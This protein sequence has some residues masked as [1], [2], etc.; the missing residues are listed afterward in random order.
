MVVKLA[1][2]E[3][4][5]AL[6][7]PRNEIPSA[8]LALNRGAFPAVLVLVASVRLLEQSILDCAF[9]RA[10]RS[11]AHAPSFEEN[12]LEGVLVRQLDVAEK[13]TS[14]EARIDTV[15]SRLIDAA[16]RHDQ[17]LHGLDSESSSRAVILGTSGGGG[18]NES[19]LDVGGV[20]LVSH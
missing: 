1:A 12:V 16:P 13:N 2:V 5:V 9:E 20:V 10:G 15:D 6:A 19:G 4:W 8:V 14:H 18:L 17:V 7:K 11:A 3:A